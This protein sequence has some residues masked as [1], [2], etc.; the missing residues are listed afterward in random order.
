MDEQPISE[1]KIGEIFQKAQHYEA[2]AYQAFCS[3]FDQQFPMPKAPNMR[4]ME[5]IGWQFIV[6]MIQSA[7]A[8]ILAAL[9]TADMFYEAASSSNILVRWGDAIAAVV[10]VEFGIV[11]FA[12]IK[13]E[14]QNRKT[15]VED[16]KSALKVNVK[17]LQVGIGVGV[18][19][20][21]IA[22]LGVSFK[23]FGVDVTGFKTV[24]AVVMGAGASIIAW[25]SGDIL[26][27]M[28]ARFGNARAL[29]DLEY[30]RDL[31]ERETK[32]HSMWEVAPE[33]S[34]ARSELNE[35]KE[36][37]KANQFRAPRAE[38]RAPSTPVALK[39]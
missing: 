31:E 7:F 16:L 32:K 5:A 21:V 13:S 4:L 39:P 18:F 30:R 3:K 36:M 14:V 17:L 22:G 12:T 26:G 28:L 20:S 38:P 27:A 2:Q 9:R 24:L 34:I 6:I 23:G 1:N 35:M 15:E 8:I 29:A 37:M 10:A 19:V 11:V 25:V 33:R